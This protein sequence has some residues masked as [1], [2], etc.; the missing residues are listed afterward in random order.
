MPTALE[1]ISPA[2]YG[3]D[4]LRL[5]L[6]DPKQRLQAFT[7]VVVSVD[8]SRCLPAGVVLPLEFTVTGPSQTSNVRTVFR[9]FA[10]REL[11]FTPREGGSFLV[12]CCEQFHNLF[13]GVL[14]LE[15]TG[16]RLEL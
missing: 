15:I 16:D 8:Y 12:R 13:F 4:F 11:V 3:S 1:E 6:S 7:P 2:Y 9:R 14:V 10:P 5:A